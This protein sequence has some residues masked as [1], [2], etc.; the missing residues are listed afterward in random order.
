MPS[1]DNQC[2]CHTFYAAPDCNGLTPLV[3]LLIVI[4]AL[5]AGVLLLL[6]GHFLSNLYVRLSATALEYRAALRRLVLIP[7]PLGACS[8]A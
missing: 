5:V 1:F 2:E 8:C 4:V 7:F 6:F 3:V